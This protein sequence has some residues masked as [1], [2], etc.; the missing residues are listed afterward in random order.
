MSLT[1]LQKSTLTITSVVV[2]PFKSPS[3][4]LPSLWS[5]RLGKYWQA[6][7]LPLMYP[8]KKDEKAKQ[9]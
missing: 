7:P 4:K 5:Q 8:H 3:L 6:L 1:N 9:S 2:V